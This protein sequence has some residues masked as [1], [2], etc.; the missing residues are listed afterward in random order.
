MQKKKNLLV[1]ATSI[2]Q[3]GVLI[4]PEKS[5]FFSFQS[6]KLR[7]T[8]VLSRTRYIYKKKGRSHWTE[9]AYLKV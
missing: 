2:H 6:P 7:A 9:C 8:L 1:R 5:V 4:L 3:S